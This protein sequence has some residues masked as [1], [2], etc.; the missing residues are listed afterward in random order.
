MKNLNTIAPISNTKNVEVK[1]IYGIVCTRNI[2]E[3]GDDLKIFDGWED[4]FTKIFD[5][6]FYEIKIWKHTIKSWTM[7]FLE[8][9][10]FTEANK[11]NFGEYKISDFVEDMK[12]NENMELTKEQMDKIVT[13]MERF[14]NS[15]KIN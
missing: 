14:V 10:K 2:E 6:G 15:L 11:K 3:I 9:K 13:Y 1:V 8:N 4:F 7:M 5:A 12:W